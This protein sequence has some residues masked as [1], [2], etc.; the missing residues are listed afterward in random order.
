M[1]KANL[2]IAGLA[3]ILLA[4]ALAVSG[5]AG[6]LAINPD[7]SNPTRS[8][9]SE[10]A[11]FSS[12]EIMFAQMMIPHHQQAV[13]MGVI[14][15][16]RSQNSE[17]LELAALI[18]AEQ[19]PEIDQMRGWL[20]EA[21]ANEDMGHAMHDMGGMLTEEQ[22]ALLLSAEGEEFDR[23]FLEGMIA[24]H[25][26]AIQMAEM[27]RGSNNSEVKELSEAIVS[28]QTEQI[29]YMRTLLTN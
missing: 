28:S 24:H 25:E 9:P 18:A 15:A 19:Q 29:Q 11:L 3:G 13:D 12:M 6:T 17:V 16:A 23:L 22:M 21:G 14:A 10:T 1:D 27:I 5:C 26:G 20:E 7:S 2:R 4:L 8:E